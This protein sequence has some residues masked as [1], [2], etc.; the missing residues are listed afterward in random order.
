M[1]YAKRYLFLLIL[2]FAGYISGYAQQL[3]LKGVLMDKES[4]LRIADA[5]IFTPSDKLLGKSNSLGEFSI[6]A[7]K[8]D[9]IIIRKNGY[10]D[11]YFNIESS[12]DLIIR[13]QPIIRLSEVIVTSQTK[14]QEL[15]EIKKQYRKKGSYYS[16]KPPLLSFIFSPLTA[17]YELIGKTPRQARRFNNFYNYELQQTEI[18]RRF[19]KFSVQKYSGFEGKDLHNFM[20]NYRPEFS[21]IYS[22]DEYQLISYIKNSAAKFVAQGK[23]ESKLALPVLPKAPD[24]RVKIKE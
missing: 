2:F 19:N 18:D 24:L 23:P 5:G 21:Q 6:L 13:L 14:K 11:Y 12:A 8:G 1:P 7:S 3:N 17:I 4:Y 9:S 10:T 16:G 15:D 20:D 22:W